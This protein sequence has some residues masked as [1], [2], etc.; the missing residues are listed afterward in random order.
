MDHSCILKTHTYTYL[1][2]YIHTY[3]HMYM[4]IFHGSVSVMKTLGCGVSHKYTYTNLQCKI[5]QTFYK[6]VINQLFSLLNSNNVF[7]VFCVAG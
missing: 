6:N 3:V 5:L 1:H 7:S 2:T 4:H